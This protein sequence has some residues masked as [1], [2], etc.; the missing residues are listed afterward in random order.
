MK[1]IYFIF[2]MFISFS[3]FSQNNLNIKWHSTI[4][5]EFINPSKVEYYYGIYNSDYDAIIGGDDEIV[6]SNPSFGAL[7]SINYNVFKK[8]SLGVITGIQ[9]MNKPDYSM[10]KLGGC[11][12]Y[13]FVDS[14]NVYTFIDI[15]Y[16]HSLNKNQFKNGMNTRIGI[17]FPVLKKDTF[18]LNINIFYEVNDLIL[19]GSQP[20]FNNEIP[21]NIIFRSY[22][23]SIGA[24]F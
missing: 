12:K 15:A 14:N 2:V 23:L 13:F 4:D 19:D 7:Y 10:I 9:Y 20:L 1:K 3:G 11:I 8:L 17:G 21:G 6:N 5:V 18:N 16:D 22:G 24:Q